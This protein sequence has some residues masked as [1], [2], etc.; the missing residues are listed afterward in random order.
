MN[1]RNRGMVLERKVDQSCKQYEMM[2]VAKIFK[3]PVEKKMIRGELKYMSKAGV[4]YNGTIQGGR[5]IAFDAKET[6]ETT[7][8]PLD[9]VHVHQYEELKGMSELGAIAFLVVSF[10]ELNKVYLLPYEI[11]ER[12][13]T[14]VTKQKRGKGSIPL[15]VFETET[16][17]IKTANGCHVDF[18]AAIK[19]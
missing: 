17:V 13:W 11:I 10:V 7:R 2:K 6:T 16:A 12:H 5:A 18:I 9:N 19:Q 1:T 4:D 3:R 8:F 14:G 15:T